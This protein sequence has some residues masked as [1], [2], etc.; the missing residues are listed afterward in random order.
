[1]SPPPRIEADNHLNVHS[2][3]RNWRMD[4]GKQVRK[5]HNT[6]EHSG[7]ISPIVRSM[8]SPS[9]F[10]P[11]RGGSSSTSSDGEIVASAPFSKSMKQG[12][13]QTI[14]DARRAGVE[15]D[16]YYSQTQHLAEAPIDEVDNSRS[17]AVI[18]LRS[19][20]IPR[21]DIENT[22][23]QG[24][25]RMSTALSSTFNFLTSRASTMKPS[26]KAQTKPE[27]NQTVNTSQRKQSSY[28]DSDRRRL[29]FR[30]NK[31]LSG[32]LGTPATITLRKASNVYAPS[33]VLSS[34]AASIAN[35]DIRK[36]TPEAPASELLAFYST[37]TIMIR[38]VKSVSTFINASQS[39]NTA[40]GSSSPE[41]SLQPVQMRSMSIAK[42]NP[43][44][45]V[46]RYSDPAE[47][48]LTFADVHVASGSFAVEPNSRKA[49][50]IPGEAFRRISV[51]HFRSRTS[52]H[53]IIWREDE[54]I[55]GSSLSSG[56]RNSASPQ[57]QDDASRSRA[58]SPEAGSI[59]QE[60]N[61]I[62]LQYE[63]LSSS[64]SAS[65]GLGRPQNRFFQW[66]WGH[67][68]TARKDTHTETDAPKEPLGL[69]HVKST[70]DP[71]IADLRTSPEPYDP[72]PIR[73]STCEEYEV[74]DIQ[75]FPPLRSRSSTSEWC[76]A[77]LVDLNDPLAGRAQQYIEKETTYFVGSGLG[78][79]QVPSGSVVLESE[80]LREHTAGRRLSS[81]PHVP[82][83]IG[84]SGRMGS[85]IGSSSHMR[86]LQGHRS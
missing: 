39:S 2:Q 7:A 72:G 48:T 19:L 63:S 36:T 54:T 65:S 8:P 78:F 12:T 56:S 47:A 13:T 42:F 30:E 74:T 15:V 79:Y 58:P 22:E 73:S 57:P 76:R 68:S 34:M 37:P 10:K 41:S 84:P 60:E 64:P 69:S 77:P 70:S 1:M 45:N 80:Q 52:V 85:S 18:A 62:D 24:L 33:P 40:K 35:E 50:L 29:T 4:G 5:H 11:R 83:R 55:S 17:S 31:G 67:P 44:P 53:E 75:S 21:D 6:R 61:G 49:S 23:P 25:R 27:G 59:Q 82:P 86:V 38:G 16:G 81:Y 14:F 51:V 9:E 66:S 32:M 46:R 71:S 20:T 26:R 43:K 3:R 28:Q